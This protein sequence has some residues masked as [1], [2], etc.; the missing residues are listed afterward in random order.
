MWHSFVDILSHILHFSYRVN[1]YVLD[2]KKFDDTLI[3]YHIYIIHP[4]FLPPK[5]E[6]KLFKA[7]LQIS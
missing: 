5:N 1:N 6:K 7:H 4:C 3:I 2:L